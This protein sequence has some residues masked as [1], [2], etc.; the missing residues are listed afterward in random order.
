M[1]NM[2]FVNF[3]SGGPTLEVRTGMSARRLYSI[4][5]LNQFSARVSRLLKFSQT[6]FGMQA[7]KT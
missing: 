4:A 6:E 2:D 5:N 7:L 3:G 1:H